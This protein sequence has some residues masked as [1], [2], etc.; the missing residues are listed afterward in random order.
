M[1]IRRRNLAI[2]TTVTLSSGWLGVI[3]NRA[4]GVPH[5]LD[6]PGAGLWL[7]LPLATTI[8]LRFAG[9]GWRRSGFSPRLPAA[10]RWY[11]AG[12]LAFPVVTAGAIALGR[13]SGWT[14]TGALD[15]PRL[16]AA[17]A[18]ALAINLI[19]NVFEESVWRGYLTEEL[20]EDGRSDLGLYLAVGAV[21][22][23][24][25][26]PYY[27]FFLDEQTMRTVID[28]PRL[29]GALVLSVTM[30]GWSVLFTEL[31]RLSGSIWPCVLMHAV[32][33]ALVNPLV[34]DGHLAFTPAG[35]VLVSPINGVLT[36]VGYVGLGL[37]LR[38]LRR[39]G[40][41]HGR[42][43]AGRGTRQPARPL[44]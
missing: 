30:L 3:L 11:V 4:M 1:R 13:L 44:R 16:A 10:A 41:G 36:T 40:W 7:A 24:W 12:A 14:D 28:L 5:D 32:E 43:R 2:F 26:L 37:A 39:R 21:W 19:K 23:L 6:S 29:P 15:V 31:Y 8:A 22:A 34:L 33:D 17:F 20:I 38:A 42:T 9:T 25:H 27:L 35:S 18:P